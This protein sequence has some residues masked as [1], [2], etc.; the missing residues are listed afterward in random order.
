[1]S[2]RTAL[3]V[4][5]VCRQLPERYPTLHVLTDGPVS[6]IRGSFVI[7]HEGRELDWF[8]IEIEVAPLREGELPTVR[9]IGGR[10]PWT[11]DRHVNG[12]GSACVCLPEDYLLNHPGP[13]DLL[14]YLDGPVR[15]FF[16]GQALVERGDPWPYGEWKHGGDGLIQWVEEFISGLPAERRRAYGV[17]LRAKEL[18]GHVQCPCGSGRRLR[19]C[20]YRLIER[21]RRGLHVEKEARRGKN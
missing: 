15:S 14:S 10:I 20:H 17:L 2:W 12:D 8:A 19:A 9:E 1:M 3:D 16:L 13:F 4:E 21:L 6:R 11:E 5:E 7:E 18:R